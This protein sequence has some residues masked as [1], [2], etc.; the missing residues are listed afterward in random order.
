MERKDFEYDVFLSYSKHDA[1]IVSGLAQR[2]RDDG[3]NIWI[4]RMISPGEFIPE[5]IEQALA[6]S[7]ILILCL[8]PFFLKSEWTS[9]ERNSRVFIDPTNKNR[10]FLPLLLEECT[11][12]DTLKSFKF[13]DFTT[14]R[15]Q[16]Y[17]ELLS[18]LYSLLGIDSLRT[19]LNFSSEIFTVMEKVAN[20]IS[21]LSL[22]VE[23]INSKVNTIQERI[24]KIDE[25][26][27]RETLEILDNKIDYVE[28][29]AILQ[30]YEIP[31][32][33]DFKTLK[34]ISDQLEGKR[35]LVKLDIDIPL[36]DDGENPTFHPKYGR[37]C[38]TLSFLLDQ[39]CIIILLVTQGLSGVDFFEKAILGGLTIHAQRLE[40]LLKV[41][42]PIIILDSLQKL[43]TYIPEAQNRDIFMLPNLLDISGKEVLVT[44]SL[45]RKI[46]KI[47]IY[48]NEMVKLLKP[49]YD[50][51]VLDDFRSTIKPLPSNT[52][53]AYQKE[54]VIG[55]GLESDISCLEH[56]IKKCIDFGK[57]KSQYRVCICGSSRPSDVLIIEALLNA[58]LF[59]KILLGPIPSLVLYQARE[60]KVNQQIRNELSLLAEYNDEDIE[61]LV[62]KTGK[63]LLNSYEK[64]IVLPVD[65]IVEKGN[66]IMTLLV[67]DL[68]DN[69][70]H[71]RGI[72]EKTVAL[73]E[74]IINDACLVFHFG[75][76]G[77]AK[78]PFI[79]CTE[80]II[81]SYARTRCETFMA[82]DHIAGIAQKI[83]VADKID[84]FITG[85]KTTSFYIT[86]RQLP[87]FELFVK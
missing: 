43:T 82:G 31:N 3:I 77:N 35:I 79:K 22:K 73:Y 59:D 4:D 15:E 23:E 30:N 71:I 62:Y 85:A 9:F 16:G 41:E 60:L 48:N 6:Q 72:G 50:I 46:S 13:I 58:R 69:K 64:Q 68:L 56:L 51:F 44:K 75:M 7:N 29:I 20:K 40:T 84:H 54:S 74:D 2:L 55:K 53:L 57:K 81:D 67:G 38:K 45:N 78:E 63:I 83:G 24:N 86:G 33:L 80:K 17:T 76:L 66:N 36:S 34:D 14:E 52:G 37:A 26:N 39:K 27:M 18:T 70:L 12:P 5:K 87:G 1:E 21:Q 19:S 28:R 10:R 65:Y 61:D 42:K 47:E 8:S 32:K 49:H 11:L 25:N